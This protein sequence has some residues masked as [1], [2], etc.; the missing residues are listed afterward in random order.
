MRKTMIKRSY[1]LKKTRNNI[2]FTHSPIDGCLI[3]ENVPF[4]Q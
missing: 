4:C 3:V 2:Y 1:Q